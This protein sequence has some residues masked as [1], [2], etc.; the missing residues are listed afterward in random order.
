MHQLYGGN[1]V[2][3][4]VKLDLTA[5][6]DL[7]E[8][9]QDSLMESCKDKEAA[10][11]AQAIAALSRFQPSEEDRAKDDEDDFVTEYMLQMMRTDPSAYVLYQILVDKCRDVRKAALINIEITKDAIPYI[12]ERARDIDTSIRRHVYKKSLFDIGS[13]R[14]FSIADRERILQWGLTDRDPTVQK[15]CADMLCNLWIKQSGDNII[16]VCRVSQ[17]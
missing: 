16:D 11:R 12:V 3:N 10:V 13:C 17:I 5:S 9:L 6:D 7:Y 14:I 4:E 2:K 1:G 15:A 8:E